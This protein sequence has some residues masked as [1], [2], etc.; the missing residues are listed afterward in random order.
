MSSLAK[1]HLFYD[2]IFIN[3]SSI[4]DSKVSESIHLIDKDKNISTVAVRKFCTYFHGPQRMNHNYFGDPSGIMGGAI[5]AISAMQ[6][7]P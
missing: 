2:Q 6:R 3:M 7:G 4:M 1:Q 5:S